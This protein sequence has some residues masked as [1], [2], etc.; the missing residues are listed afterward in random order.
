M[1][2]MKIEFE[3]GHQGQ[4]YQEID[5]NMDHVIRLTDLDGNTLN[6]E[7]PYGYYIIDKDPPTPTWAN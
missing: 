7:P 3:Y 5:S 6:L 1:R 4:G 2:Y